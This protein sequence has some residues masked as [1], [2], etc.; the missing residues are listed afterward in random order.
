MKNAKFAITALFFAVAG[1]AVA[2]P[3]SNAAVPTVTVSASN[4][5][6]ANSGEG[7][8]GNSYFVS[9]KTRAQVV[10]ELYDARKN[11]QIFDGE[12]YPG[13]LV[14]ASSKSRAEVVAELKDYRAS[15]PQLAED[16]ELFQAR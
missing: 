13:P 8:Q 2:A 1:A 16:G 3:G 4:Y 7:Y 9:T 10:Q 15:H 6:G 14:S 12:A 11:G 5:I